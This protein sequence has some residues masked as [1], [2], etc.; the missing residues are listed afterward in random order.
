[1]EGF[2][3]YPHYRECDEQPDGFPC[4]CEHIASQQFEEYQE[5]LIKDSLVDSPLVDEA[6]KDTADLDLI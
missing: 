2:Y 4:V 6:D 5:G 1:M 3:S